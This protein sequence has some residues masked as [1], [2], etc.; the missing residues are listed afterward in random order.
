MMSAYLDRLGLSAPPLLDIDGLAALQR[1]HGRSIGFENLDVRLGRTIRIDSQS[2]FEKL[3]QRRRGGYC[4]EQNRLF[5]DALKALGTTNR[6]ILA[7]G[8][9]NEPPGPVPPFT[10]MCLLVE[11]EG[12]DWLIDAGFGGMVIAPVPIQDGAVTRSGHRLRRIGQPADRGSEWLLEWAP[13]ALTAPQDSIPETA[14]QP[15]Y[16]FDLS[17]VVQSDLEQASHWTST[18]ADI[19]FTTSHIV[20]IAL[21]DGFAALTDRQLSVYR[22]GER[23]IS[24]IDDAASYGAVVRDMFRI[25]L[26]DA[27]AAALPLFADA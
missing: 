3:V 13:T 25:D 8:L 27:D 21:A 1:A 4:F 11:R 17:H 24:Q 16:S 12:Q 20:S 23:Q 26:C 2:V 18:R 7:R 9:L 19:R 14:W 6:P 22:Q 5:S 15:Q 10:H